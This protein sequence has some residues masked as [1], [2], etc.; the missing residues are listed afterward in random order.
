MSEGHQVHFLQCFVDHP[1][2]VRLRN[3]LEASVEVQMLLWGEFLPQQIELRAHSYG[4]P[5]PVHISS[6]GQSFHPGI[7][8]SWRIQPRQN[9]YEARFSS[10]VGSQKP[11]YLILSDGE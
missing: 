9:T 7:A 6:D 5:D 10:S 3:A 2:N 8:T 11:K 1:A 4:K